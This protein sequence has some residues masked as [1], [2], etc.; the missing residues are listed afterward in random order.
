MASTVVMGTEY[1]NKGHRTLV[2]QSLS[3]CT[4]FLVGYFWMVI[5]LTFYRIWRI[6][7]LPGR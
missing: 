3:F 1:T 2:R 6:Y 7:L 4:G 5:L